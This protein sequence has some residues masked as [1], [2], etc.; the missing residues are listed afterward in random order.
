M[1]RIASRALSPIVPG[2]V[3]LLGLSFSARAEAPRA[4]AWAIGGVDVDAK[5]AS[6]TLDEKIGQL[7][8]L[9]FG[10][11]V[12]DETIS[13]FLRD[14]KPG[15]VALF[16][17]NIKTPEQTMDLIRAVREHDP[18]G[19]PI[20][21]SVD[22]EGGNVVRLHEATIPPSNMAIG[23]TGSTEL[24]ERMGRAL[25][26]DLALMGF[27]MNLA[28]VLD[29]NSNPANPVIGIRSFGGSPELV[30]TMGVAF[31]HG[32]Q[33]EGVVA[34]AKHFPGHG[35]T[36]TDSHFAM[37]Q[38]DHDRDRLFAVELRPFA[39][40]LA[41]GLDALMTAHISLPRIAEEPEMP[42]TVSENVLGKILR[43]EL[44]Y[45]GLV[46]TDG[47]E[48]E[49]IVSKY[50]SGE[51]AVRAVLAG[52]DMVM[53]LWFPERKNEVHRALKDAV[54][55]GRIS[56]E[57]LDRSVRRVLAAK[58]RRGLFT[59]KLL[60]TAD[61]LQALSRAEHRKIIGEVAERA[62]TLVRNEGGVLPLQADAK[63][64]VATTEPGFASALHRRTKSAGVVRLP[65]TPKKG[66]PASFA[67]SV[68]ARAKKTKPDVVV[69]GAM[70]AGWAP[71]VA[72]V[73]R[74]LPGTKVVAVSFGSPYML[75]DFPDVDAYLCAYAFRSESE[76]AAAKAIV[77]ELSPTGT[78]PVDL[79]TGQKLGH[80]LKY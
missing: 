20:F 47:L 69:V 44:G 74:Q 18:A 76:V 37:P 46:I 66:Q 56:K 51:A 7:L 53:V 58:A 23:A 19:V 34:V 80:G 71:L 26:K 16:A 48:M 55:S 65:G 68:V 39:R 6:L 63:V 41:E 3:C 30:A 1:F 52:A 70:K 14:K 49:G 27:N 8:F 73:Q 31:T 9:G 77:G 32:M 2:L 36:S 15:A 57:R 22:Q 43:D 28:P 67:K 78:L 50:G 12:M 54:V 38:I 40:S 61:A 60:P 75:S 17:R 62:I 42:A 79:P 11:K 10:G 21:I 72:E 33:A 13:S 5:L 24:A 29:V 64:L 59:T 25:G 45:Q 4:S 35:D